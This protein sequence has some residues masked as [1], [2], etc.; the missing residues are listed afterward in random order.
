MEVRREQLK[1]KRKD[2]KLDIRWEQQM[3]TL[4][5]AQKGCLMEKKSEMKKV[6]K[7]RR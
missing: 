1:V 3:A 2:S 6:M 4:L 5:E 7:E